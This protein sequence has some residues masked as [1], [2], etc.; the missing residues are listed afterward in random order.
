[1]NKNY[2]EILCCP[3]CKSSLY[4]EGDT[5]KTDTILEGELSCQGCGK[6]FPVK[7]GIVRFIKMEELGKVERR[8]ENFRR[9]FY[10]YIYEPFT[11]FEF[12]FCGGEKKARHECLDR[13]EIR[14]GSRI[15]ETGIGTGSNLPYLTDSLDE[16]CFF[17]VDISSSML[18]NCRQNLK[19]WGCPAEIFLAR[20]ESLPFKDK[21]FDTV[22]HLGAINIFE[23]KKQAIDE[24]IR[25]ARPGTKIVIADET[26]EADKLRDKLLIPRLLGKREEVVPPINLVPKTMTEIRLDTIWNG[27]GYCIEFRTPLS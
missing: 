7:K 2:L 22:F 24:M 6:R 9:V 4:L 15:L 12:I 1:M 3:L 23:R 18:R 16:G 11:R 5:E 13:L 26:E 10:S 25:V 21:T 17:G 14:P 20:A 27:Y 19:R 8:F